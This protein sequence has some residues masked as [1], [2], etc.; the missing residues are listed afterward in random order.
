MEE[1]HN[2][3]YSK[4]HHTSLCSYSEKSEPEYVSSNSF[5]I[6]LKLPE[7][8]EVKIDAHFCSHKWK[9]LDAFTF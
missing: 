2:E 9:I 5:E 8:F 7:R 1:S 4:L 3:Y 6:D